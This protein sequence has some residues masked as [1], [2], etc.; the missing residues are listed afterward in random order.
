MMALVAFLWPSTIQVVVPEPA[1]RPFCEK[2]VSSNQPLTRTKREDSYMT[3]AGLKSSNQEQPGAHG[4]GT[5][6]SRKD[7]QVNPISV[8]EED[9]KS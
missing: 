3:V 6:A 5:T 4:N 8:Q 1:T 9:E 2:E 7:R